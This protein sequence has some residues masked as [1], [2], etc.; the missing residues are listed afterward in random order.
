MDAGATFAKEYHLTP[1]IAL[2][3][4]QMAQLTSDIVWMVSQTVTL[5]DGSTQQVLVPQV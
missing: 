1:G 4:E 2:T 5:P 3:P